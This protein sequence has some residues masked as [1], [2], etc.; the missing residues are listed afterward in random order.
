[1]AMNGMLSVAYPAVYRSFT[2]NFGFSAGLVSWDAL[3]TGIDGFR[4]STGGNLTR[5]S[6]GFLSNTTLVF[7]GDLSK[8][9]L[10]SAGDAVLLIRDIITNVNGSTTT[11]GN[12]T[13]TTTTSTTTTTTK[14]ENIVTGIRGYVEELSIPASNTFMTVLVLFAIVIAAITASILLLKLLLEAW[15]LFGTF[16]ARLSNFRKQYWWLLAKTITNLILLLYG[17]WTLYC[18][19]Q[20][21][22]GDS[23]AA[24][25]LAGATLGIFTLVLV[26]FTY[27][28]YRKA[29]EEEAADRLYSDKETWRRYSL[30]YENYKS[31]YWW[32]FVPTIIY[33]F[34]KGCIIA[35]ADGHGLIQ[36]AGQLSADALMLLLLLLTRPYSLASGNWINVVIQIVRVASCCCILI[37]V[38]ELGFSASTKTVVGLVLVIIQAVLTGLLALLIAVNAIVTCVRANPHR[39]RRKEAERK[40]KSLD[41]DLTPLDARNSLL[42]HDMHKT[43]LTKSTPVE[44]DFNV[45]SLHTRGRSKGGHAYNI[46]SPR[47]PSTHDFSPPPVRSK[48]APPSSY[49]YNNNNN[50]QYDRRRRS[51]EREGLRGGAAGFAGQRPSNE[52]R[53]TS[54]ETQQQRARNNSWSS[55]APSYYTDP[56]P[57]DERHFGFGAPQS[58]GQP[59][60]YGR[61]WSYRGRGA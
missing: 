33:M 35:L 16:P 31:S 15:A 50:P 38:E 10:P 53:R 48:A 44:S 54:N 43:P 19:Y 32:L 34:A 60:G 22:S 3:Q 5:D 47:E 28:I 39:M 41:D 45:V 17:V 46:V 21:R 25:A 37:F 2:Q 9:A 8:R 49:N 29:H 1:M 24:K 23:W 36:T 26:G 30:F 14:P 55:Y 51:S 40:L 12:N 52:A 18:I 57:T 56:T 11:V 59:Q 4:R 61:D 13:T 27:K 7:D 58:Q 42:L 6:V 20:F